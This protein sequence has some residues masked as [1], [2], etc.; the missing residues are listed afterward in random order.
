M[1]KQKA[2]I[3]CSTQEDT[4]HVWSSRF[5]IKAS[6]A[7][8]KSFGKSDSEKD[9][10]KKLITHAFST[11]GAASHANRTLSLCLDL[12]SFFLSTQSPGLSES[13]GP[14]GETRREVLAGLAYPTECP[15]H[16][17]AVWLSRRWLGLV[18]AVK[19]QEV[20][21]PHFCR[22]I[23]LNWR[24]LKQES[25]NQRNWD[26]NCWTHFGCDPLFQVLGQRH[27]L[28]STCKISSHSSSDCLY[29]RKTSQK[30][31]QRWF[32]WGEY[33]FEHAMGPLLRWLGSH[34]PSQQRPAQSDL[35][36]SWKKQD[37]ETSGNASFFKPSHTKKKISFWLFTINHCYHHYYYHYPY[38]F[39]QA[40]STFLGNN[41]LTNQRRFFHKFSIRLP[42]TPV[43]WLRCH[44][45]PGFHRS[46]AAS[47]FKAN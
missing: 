33:Q 42:M 8:Y 6:N 29:K 4:H 38:W 10:L 41:D 13:I 11:I 12:S 15:H 18:L 9:I 43:D 32:S 47:L 26:I 37:W 7:N 40:K 24:C 3:K 27:N 46:A 19:S 20:K 35:A 44:K 17:W 28:S 1:S 22:R 2:K 30:M 31:S 5:P 25:P 23:F 21:R 14:A 34:I 39:S 36:M 16:P 45:G